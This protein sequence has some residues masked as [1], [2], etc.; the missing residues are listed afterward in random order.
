MRI[1]EKI[2]I[3]ELQKGN[4]EVLESLYKDYYPGLV[5]FAEGFVFDRNVCQDIVQNLF[6]Q[7]WEK[8]RELDFRTS[9]KAYLYQATRNR[10]LN[11]L[12]NVNVRDRHNLLY[13]EAMIN[14]HDQD[15]HVDETWLKEIG[16][17]LEKLPH[18]MARVFHLKYM[19]GKKIREIADDLQI[20]ENSVKT[21]LTRG[22]ARLRL[23]SSQS[24]VECRM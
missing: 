15:P 3:R 23:L 5:M 6:V 24:D 10:C 2:I 1:E 14:S 17:A 13:L 21:N 8:S 16:L 18:Q 12:R 7:L 22:K 11:H 9:I 20:S 19:Q 4:R